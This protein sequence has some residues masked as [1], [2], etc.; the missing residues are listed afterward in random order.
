MGKAANGDWDS[1]R[2]YVTGRNNYGQLGTGN[3]TNVGFWTA[4]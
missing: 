2:L 3:T 1:G 4:K